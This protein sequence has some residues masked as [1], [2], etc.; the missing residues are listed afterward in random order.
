MVFRSIL[1]LFVVFLATSCKGPPKGIERIPATGEKRKQPE[2]TT[3]NEGDQTRKSPAFH[4]SSQTLSFSDPVDDG[5]HIR[6]TWVTHHVF[7]AKGFDPNAT[8]K[9]LAAAGF[10]TIYV[11]VYA[12]GKPKWASAAYKAAGGVAERSEPLFAFVEAL[13]QEKLHVAAWFEYGLALYPLNHPIALAHPSWLQQTVGGAT[14]GN[15]PQR[16]LSPSH[17]EVHS[18]MAAMVTELAEFELFNEIQLDRL[19]YTRNSSEGREFGYEAVALQKFKNQTN[20]TLTPT[21]DDAA[22]VR[23][24]E[25]EVNAIVKTCYDAIKKVSPHILVSIAP[26]GHYGI[27]QHLQRWTDW[28]IEESI[29]SITIQVYNTDINAFKG[30]LDRQI[31]ELNAAQSVSFKSRL[32]IGLRAHDSDDATQTQASLEYM[33]TH[34]LHNVSLWAYHQ[35]NPPSFGIDD[36]LFVLKAQTKKSWNTVP[37]HPFIRFTRSGD[38]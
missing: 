25:K 19:R 23:F 16:F 29:D 5:R 38:P 24:R 13:R 22:W 7:E 15:E 3:P 17:P 37:A 26:V 32:V 6:A 9:N 4:P 21:K 35:F 2:V 14:Q 36:D 33:S 18:L 1:L 11:A 27:R 12:S 20:T 34:G 31:N 30:H 8:A 28:I 10:N